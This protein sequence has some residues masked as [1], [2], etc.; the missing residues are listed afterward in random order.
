MKTMT[1]FLMLLF[2]IQTTSVVPAEFFESDAAQAMK[3][4]AIVGAGMG[5][6][7]ICSRQVML[8]AWL[9]NAKQN[10]HLLDSLDGVHVTWVNLSGRGLFQ[11]NHVTMENKVAF[12]AM[13]ESE[14]IVLEHMAKQSFLS[15]ASKAMVQHIFVGGCMGLLSSLILGIYKAQDIN[16][17]AEFNTSE[18]GSKTYQDNQRFAAA[19][20]SFKTA[21]FG[22]TEYKTLLAALMSFVGTLAV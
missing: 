20:D 16:S 5:V 21:T 15:Q 6:V 17:L 4:G 13:I 22:K 14:L 18:P 10:L 11:Q 12:R 19:C 9:T 2:C 3:V 7:G 1:K 8:D